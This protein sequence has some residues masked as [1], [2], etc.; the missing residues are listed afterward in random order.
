MANDYK[1]IESELFDIRRQLTEMNVN[2]VS[3]ARAIAPEQDELPDAMT[4]IEFRMY[5]PTE[6]LVANVYNK[7]DFARVTIDVPDFKRFI[8][9]I[10]RSRMVVEA[11]A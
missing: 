6:K 4:S 2:L 11:E 1:K 10:Q 3:V 9:L 8:E 5:E 7:G